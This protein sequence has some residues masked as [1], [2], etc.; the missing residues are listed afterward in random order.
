MIRRS[1]AE[2]AR[3][4]ASELLAQT[5]I[6]VRQ[7]ELQGMQVA[8]FGLSR[9]AVAGV[10]IVTLVDTDH[11]AVKLLIL[12][13]HQTEPEHWH[14]EIGDYP[15]KEETVRCEWGELYL[16][17]PGTRT[18][19]PRGHP[20]ADRLGTYTVWH[21]YVLH[22]SDQVTVQPGE[23]HW[24]QAGPQGAVVWTFS[25]KAVDVADQF[26]DPE[27]VRETVMVDG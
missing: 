9:L 13:P 8:D 21:E 25:T 26:T 1:E 5:G 16:Y 2:H 11:V 7:S 6:A 12:T 18:A 3:E 17:G 19:H 14:P 27:I 10:Q 20:P 24:F 23:R 22:P 15:G 4:V